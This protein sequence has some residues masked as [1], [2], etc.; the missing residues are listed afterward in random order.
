MTQAV[1][2]AAI[3]EAERYVGAVD[4]SAHTP[5]VA[6]TA[7]TAAIGVWPG[8][9]SSDSLVLEDVLAYQRDLWERT[10]LFWDTLR[11]RADNMIAHERAGK[12][13]LL[14]FDY[15]LILDA[16]RFERPV[17]YALLRI[18]RYGDKCLE[19]CLNPTKPPVM[20]VDP[21]AGHGPG[22]G[23]FKRESEV[24]IALHEGYP[25]YFVVFYPEPA[26]GQSMA[27]VL[28]ALRRFV[29]E[30]SRRHETKPP[31]LYG[32]CQAGWAIAILAADCQGLAG[33]AVLNGSPLSYWAGESGINPARVSG[34]L[35]GG[36]WLTHL[37]ADLG[38]GRFDGAWLAQNFENLKPEGVWEKY[39]NLF[40]HLDRERERFLDFERWWNGFYFLSREEMLAI[41]EN[42]FIGNSLEQGKLKVCPDCLVDL[43]RIHNPLVIFASYGDNITPPHQAI[44]WIPTVYA[45]TDDLKKA[46][47]RIVYLINPHV[48]HLGIFVSASVARLEHRAIFDSLKKIEALAPGLYE[49]K[50]DNPTGD[51]D[52]GHDAY[53]VRFEERRVEDLKFSENRPAFRRVAEVSAELDALYSA[54]LGK[55]IEATS[56]PLTAQ[57]LE[58]LHP[59]RV[60]R[61]AFAS[62]F[63][64][65]LR[66]WAPIA[67]SIV[68]DRHAV[69][70]ANSIKVREN[71]ALG[72][73]HDIIMR[74]RELR[75]QAYEAWFE[76]L[77][78]RGAAAVSAAASAEPQPISQPASGRTT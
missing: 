64:P 57:W 22:I 12:P 15:E 62:D 70:D 48:G 39:A 27:H 38:D 50:I 32:N 74:T 46:G 47:Q 54:T 35:L 10:I 17:N 42:L 29:E 18:T 37:T 2:P 52:C 45:G 31:I 71:E 75:D 77:Y 3:S 7:P 14:D 4:H 60:S 16:R 9:W 51:P 34:G 11:Q 5:P 43:R 58:W 21:R 23:G 61:Y 8:G 6:G 73:V 1:S 68:R 19:D 33:P 13:P 30:V 53:E 63:N 59:M 67:A 41:V 44:G 76:A 72:A 24:G 66:A 28:H 26:P 69:P 20:I 25:V 78:G 40:S 55:W 65:W 56:T 49:M 36:A